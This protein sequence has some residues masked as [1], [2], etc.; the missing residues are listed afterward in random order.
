MFSG[1]GKLKSPTLFQLDNKIEKSPQEN[2]KRK[3]LTVW[4]TINKEETE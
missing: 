2:L 4:K 3:F 1:S